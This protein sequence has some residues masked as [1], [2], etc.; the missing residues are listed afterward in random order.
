MGKMTSE[1]PYQVTSKRKTKSRSKTP[2]KKKEGLKKT[3][4]GFINPV[5]NI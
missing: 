3:E 5:S 4:S 1:D 2:R